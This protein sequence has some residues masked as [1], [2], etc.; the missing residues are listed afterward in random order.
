VQQPSQP[1]GPFFLRGCD[2]PSD[3]AVSGMPAFSARSDPRTATGSFE[4]P[5]DLERHAR[6]ICDAAPVVDDRLDA[7]YFA[8]R[9]SRRSSQLAAAASGGVA[10]S[11]TEAAAWHPAPLPDKGVDDRLGAYQR[12]E[13]ERRRGLGRA[14]LAAEARSAADE[15]EALR[16]RCA[17]VEG[18]LGAAAQPGV[19]DE[20]AREWRSRRGRRRRPGAG[21]G[22]L[23]QRR[24]QALGS[25][26]S[27]LWRRSRQHQARLASAVPC[28]DTGCEDVHD[29]L[30]ALLWGAGKA[31]R[32]GSR[33]GGQ[34]KKGSVRVLRRRPTLMALAHRRRARAAQAVFRRRQARQLAVSAAVPSGVKP[35]V[36]ARMSP[37]LR[38]ARELAAVRVLRWLS[39]LGLS[40]DEHARE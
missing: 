38:E 25:G 10:S 15:G 26:G 11:G 21:D 23:L 7:Q 5:V 37:A 4:P 36:D 31:G 8:H 6:R 19:A 17:R 9:S 30:V 3:N 18:Q 33:G 34:S 20:V 35:A 1:P 12:A 40:H 14:R 2:A 27:G 16:R 29:S 13:L 22:A 28:V 24:S 39:S 32:G